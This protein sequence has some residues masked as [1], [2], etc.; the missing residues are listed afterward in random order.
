MYT[1]LQTCIRKDTNILKRKGWKKI[2][3]ANSKPKKSGVILLL[4]D[5][6]DFKVGVLQGMSD[7]LLQNKERARSSGRN[8]NQLKT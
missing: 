2:Y 8:K 5:N 6:I 1:Y 7:S 4:S 3:Q